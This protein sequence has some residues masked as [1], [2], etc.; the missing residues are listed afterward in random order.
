[1][2]NQQASSEALT[3]LLK[4][5]IHLSNLLYARVIAARENIGKETGFVVRLVREVLENPFRRARRPGSRREN[6]NPRRS[7]RNQRSG[8]RAE[9]N[10]ESGDRWSAATSIPP[11][12]LTFKNTYSNDRGFAPLPA[13][14][15]CQVVRA[16]VRA[17]SNPCQSHLRT[18]SRWL[19]L[20]QLLMY[21]LIQSMPH[22]WQFTSLKFSL[23]QIRRAQEAVPGSGHHP[24]ESSLR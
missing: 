19:F 20:H 24:H 7:L 18:L 22:P 16:S 5:Q 12:V 1:M 23:H 10:E 2:E 6:R 14:H 8:I 9:A 17:G 4:N 11:G 21:Q 13:G 3:G 15:T